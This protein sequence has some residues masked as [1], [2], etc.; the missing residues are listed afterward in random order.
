[1]P[2]VSRLWVPLDLVPGTLVQASRHLD[3]RGANVPI[4]T[5]GVVI[6]PANDPV[7]S[8]GCGPVVRWLA[9]A[10]DNKGGVSNVYF[11]DVEVLD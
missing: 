9:G 11:G 4:G 7:W 10:K 1:M 8:P 6:Y 2:G 3:P 5:K